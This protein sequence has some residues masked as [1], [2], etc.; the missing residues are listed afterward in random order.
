MLN[1]SAKLNPKVLQED[2]E[3]V[4]IR[5]G[6][7]EGE[8]RILGASQDRSMTGRGGVAEFFSR[9]ISVTW[10]NVSLRQILC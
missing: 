9:K 1:D 5:K 6:F 7:G 4:P 10:V 3:R 8:K 2:V